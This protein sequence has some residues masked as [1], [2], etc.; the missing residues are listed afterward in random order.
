VVGSEKTDKW[1]GMLGISCAI[2]LK[3]KQSNG[4]SEE[5]NG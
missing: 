3:L 4:E 1:A 5:I 2:K